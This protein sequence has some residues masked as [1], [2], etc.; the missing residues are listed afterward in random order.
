MNGP[1]LIALLVGALV[2]LATFELWWWRLFAPRRFAIVTLLTDSNDF[3]LG[4]LT[5]AKSLRLQVR[6]ARAA[7]SRPRPLSPEA[8]VMAAERDNVDVT[9]DDADADASDAPPPA[10]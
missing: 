8:S 4:A 2:L 7:R 5:L 10:V 9:D 1:L 3:A 6:A